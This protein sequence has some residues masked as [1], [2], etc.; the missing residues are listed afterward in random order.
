MSATLPIDL[1]PDA[2]HAE[3]AAQLAAGTLDI[4]PADLQAFDLDPSTLGADDFALTSQIKTRYHV[5]QRSKPL[6]PR[7]IVYEHAQRLA[8][9]LGPL[10][11]PGDRAHA[12]VSGQ[13]VFGE[14]IEAW[15]KANNWLIP[16]LYCA[17]LSLSGDNIDSLANL[18]HGDY[19]QRLHLTVSDYWYSHERGR[20]GLV[21]Y[22]YKELD[23]DPDGDR[24]QL[25]VTGSHAKVTLMAPEEGGHYTLHGSANLRSSASIEQFAL[26]NDADLYAFHLAWIQALESQYHT[27]DN[28][29]GAAPK[30]HQWQAVQQAAAPSKSP[31]TPDHAP[32]TNS[33]PPPPSAAPKHADARS[34][35]SE[36]DRPS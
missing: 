17:T 2:L 34:A 32:R 5:P 3:L 18:L 12:V 30:R 7:L 13:F 25:S 31:T 11:E 33:A 15:I 6:H 27:I 28:R 10:A 9:D 14:F 29:R 24:F 19:V 35:P 20:N 23:I 36:I 4:D 22:A 1:D 8:A 16:D 21:G 26:K